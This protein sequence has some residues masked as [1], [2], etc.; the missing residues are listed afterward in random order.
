MPAHV[1]LLY[2]IVLGPGRR[3]VMADMKAAAEGIG[4]QDVQTLLATG[5][6]IFEAEARDVAIIEAELEAAFERKFGK[7]TPIL[8]RSAAAWRAL[9][10]ANPFPAQSAENGSRVV[11]RVMRDGVGAAAM[12]RLRTLAAAG[13]QVECVAGDIWAAF[14]GTMSP[15]RLFTAINAV[16]LGIGT[17]RNWNTVR[18][19]GDRLPS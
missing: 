9:V 17:S 19:I 7:R 11:V 10:A 8:V 5:N 16:K 2:S 3:V 4:L 18:R 14:P 6:L 13:E 1:A 12:D 15:S